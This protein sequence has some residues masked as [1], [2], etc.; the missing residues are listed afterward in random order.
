M[1]VLCLDVGTSAVKAAVIDP[2]GAVRASGT[3]EYPT[4]RV[5]GGGVE[6]SPLDWWTA[7][8]TAIAQCGAAVGQVRALSVTGQMQDL[9]VLDGVTPVRDALLYSDLRAGAEHAEL[10]AALQGWD[11]RAGTVQDQ[12]NVAAKMLWLGRH[13]PATLARATGVVFGPAGYLLKRC[14][15]P[16]LCDVTTASATGLLDLAAR[17]WNEDVL[18]AASI[19]RALLPTLVDAAGLLPAAHE[20]PTARGKRMALRQP[21]VHAELSAAAARE[22]GLPAGIALVCAAGDAGAATDGLVGDEPGA[23]YLYLGTTGWLAK[24]SEPG[25]RGTAHPSMHRLAMPGGSELAIAAVLHAGSAVDWARRTFLPGRS[26]AD[27]EAQLPT[28]RTSGLLCLPGL[29]GERSPVRDPHARGT[30]V[31]AGP[32][33]TAEDFYLATLEGVA[34]AFRHVADELGVGDGVLPAVGGGVRSAA[35]RQVLADVLD[36]PIVA[37]ADVDSGTHSAARAA[38]RALGEPVPAPLLAT[39]RDSIAHDA[40]ARNAVA[41]DEHRADP[42]SRSADYRRLAPVHHDLYGTLAETFRRLSTATAA[43]RKDPDHA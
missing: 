6:Q 9:I 28:H 33:T 7:S 40:T 17:D 24:I 8:A 22:L 14:G 30:F 10:A 43:D 37:I 11:D 21:A 3:A 19:D 41:R 27:L 2:D 5:G 39:A 16:A 25:P 31:G 29:A 18:D 32:D 12:S 35:W 15:A 36:R 42:G 4:H 1:S 34:F 13:E 23:A 38:Y 26:F 20:D